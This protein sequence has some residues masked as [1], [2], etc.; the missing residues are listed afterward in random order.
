MKKEKRKFKKKYLKNKQ[1]GVK[2]TRKLKIYIGPL[3]PK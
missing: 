1:N 2:K 3:L